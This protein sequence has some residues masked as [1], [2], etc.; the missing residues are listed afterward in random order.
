[1]NDSGLASPFFLVLQ[2]L[3]DDPEQAVLNRTS[4]LSASALLF[5][6]LTGSAFLKTLLYPKVSSPSSCWPSESTFV[7]VCTKKSPAL[8]S[9]NSN[10]SVSSRFRPMK[11]NL[12]YYHSYTLS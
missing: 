9:S 4:L 6:F 3:V 10:K 5:T 11:C 12:M 7:Y 8:P 1:M 2:L